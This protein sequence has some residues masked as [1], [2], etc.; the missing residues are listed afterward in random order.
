MDGLVISII[1]SIIT[2]VITG[3]VSSVLVTRLSRFETLRG[4]AQRLLRGLQYMQ[5]GEDGVDI[6]GGQPDV[7]A[8]THI[9]SDFYA[10]GHQAAGAAI[11]ELISS[12]HRTLQNPQS[13]LAI[14]GADSEWQCVGRSLKPNMK[15]IL[16]FSLQI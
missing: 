2:G 6:I 11:N 5:R 7:T 3:F 15:A 4:E 8:L 14:Q 16:R 12:V 1:V 13:Y 10:L 9:A